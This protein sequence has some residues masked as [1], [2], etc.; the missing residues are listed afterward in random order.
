MKCVV[1]G[2]HQEGKSVFMSVSDP[3]HSVTFAHGNRMQVK[4]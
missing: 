3:P 1:T 4:R 2:H